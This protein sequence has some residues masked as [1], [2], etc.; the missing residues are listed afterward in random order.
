MPSLGGLAGALYNMGQMARED[1]LRQLTDN[2]QTQDRVIKF[3][4]GVVG[5]ESFDPQI[6]QRA[7]G[8]LGQLMSEGPDK[9]KPEKWS[10]DKELGLGEYYQQTVLGQQQGP[11]QAPRGGFV[12]GPKPQY[13][14]QNTIWS[15]DT[16]TGATTQGP[17]GGSQRPPD[18][19]Q[20]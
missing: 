2:K 1:K 4:E 6:R 20:P 14:P 10:P 12:P 13:D 16:S 15:Y 3:Y 19:P 9:F 17:A 5:N 8:V 18:A 11:Q 7:F